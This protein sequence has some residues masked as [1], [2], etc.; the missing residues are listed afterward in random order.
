MGYRQNTLDALVLLE[1]QS[2]PLASGMSLCEWLL[3]QLNTTPRNAGP[4]LKSHYLGD[5][6]RRIRSSKSPSATE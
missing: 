6:G 4:S 5:E 3:L 1:T 2:H